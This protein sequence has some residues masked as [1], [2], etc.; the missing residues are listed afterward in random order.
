MHLTI[1]L[2]SKK[3]QVIRWSQHDH[4][5][6]SRVDNSLKHD[7]AAVF[8][9]KVC[10]ATGESEHLFGLGPGDLALTGSRG[11]R[12]RLQCLLPGTCRCRECKPIILHD[13]CACPTIRPEQC[14]NCRFAACCR[15]DSPEELQTRTCSK[16]I[17]PLERQAKTQ[18]RTRCAC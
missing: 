12:R 13:Y 8:G 9:G 14:G 4:N 7:H 2:H 11:V 15:R 5:A 3:A 18:E 1:C 6:K 17:S 10:D 16:P